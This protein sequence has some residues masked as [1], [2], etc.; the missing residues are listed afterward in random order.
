MDIVIL[1]AGYA[2]LRTALD[3]AEAKRKGELEEATITLVDRNDYHQVITW[4]H[5]VAAAKVAPD[6]ARVPFDRLFKD[7][8]VRLVKG[9]V[10]GISPQEQCVVLEEG[11]LIRYDRLVVAL[12]SSTW[13]PPIPGLRDH[14]LPMRWWD[15]AVEIREAIL[16]AFAQAAQTTDPAERRRLLTTIVIGGG[17]TGCQ[18][19]GELTHWLPTLADEYDISLRDITLWQVE[20]RER[21]MPNFD[22]KLAEKAE[23]V[24]RRKG[25]QMLL[26][27][28]VE[29]IDATTVTVKDKPPIPYGVAVWSGGIREP[30]LL[31]ESGFPVGA[32]GR[33]K[34][35][36][37]LRV[38]GYPDIFVIGDCALWMDGDEPLPATASHALRQGEYVARMLRRESSGKGLAAYEPTKLGL[39][40]S[41]GG[42][43]GVGTALGIPLSG[44]TA[45]ILKEG[46][47]AWYLSTIK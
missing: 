27:S 38:Q 7:D 47:E 16:F 30:K 15:E 18:L 10:R 36:E 12:G 9:T 31:E 3:L 14:A 43:D 40:V 20:A 8:I 46:I 6:K 34:V 33:V 1:G 42:N 32:Q 39:V 28:P 41:L 45:G 21:L 37:Y 2:G 11:D 22:A 4:L 24:L 29:H 23:Q 19:A 25:V 17:Y 13:W 35:D 5:E 26:N 44:L